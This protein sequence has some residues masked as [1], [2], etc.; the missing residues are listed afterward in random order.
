MFRGTR[1]PSYRGIHQ[2]EFLFD[3]IPMRKEFVGY[4]ISYERQNLY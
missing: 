1:N 2:I 3:N 4:F